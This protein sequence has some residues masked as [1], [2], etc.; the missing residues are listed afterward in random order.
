VLSSPPYALAPVTFRFRGLI[1]LAERLPLGGEREVVL[2]TFLAARLLWDSTGEAPLEGPLRRGRAQNARTWLPT[3]ALSQN[4]RAAF[5]GLFDALASDDRTAQASAWDRVAGA[6][7][8]LLDGPARNDLKT[9]AAR[10]ARE[11]GVSTPR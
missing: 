10:L 11:T 1:A 6:I 2:A 9:I 3:L 7:S 8:K 5:Q 4:V